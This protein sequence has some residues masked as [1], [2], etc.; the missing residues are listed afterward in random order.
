MGEIYQKITLAPSTV[1]TA[2]SINLVR[3]KMTKAEPV[4]RSIYVVDESNKLLGIITLKELL[5]VLAV[6]GGISSGEIPTRGKLLCYISAN[7][8]AKD[9]MRPPTSVKTTDSLEKA[10]E[11]FVSHGLEELPVVDENNVVIGD[12]DAYE[13][14]GEMQFKS[15]GS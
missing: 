9:I 7:T 1:S 10:L 6:R 5:K 3:K 12:L 11:I 15:S 2:D 8:T 13:L 14:L 4:N